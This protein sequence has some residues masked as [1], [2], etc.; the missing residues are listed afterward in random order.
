MAAQLARH[1]ISCRII[2]KNQRRTDLSRAL[3]LFARSLELLNSGIDAHALIE[4][5]I[6]VQRASFYADQKPIGSLELTGAH[7][8]FGTG[9][10]IPQSDTEQVL[11]ESLSP[12]GIRVERETELT[13]FEDLHD[14]VRCNLATSNGEQIIEPTWLI[15]CDGARSVIRHGL[16]MTFKGDSM[17]IRWVLADVRVEGV[18]DTSTL[19]ICPHA[20]GLLVGFRIRDDRLRIVATSPLA[21]LDQP[22]VDPDLADVQQLV[23][24]RGPGGWKV[25]D[26]VWLTEFRVN[27]RMVD[28]Y[29]AGHVFLAGD[30][31][32]IHSPAGG[33]GMNTG[34]QDACNLAW[35][36]ALVHRGTAN[37]NLLNS[38][39]T[40]RREVGR[41]VLAN[42]GRMTRV[43][44]MRWAVGR[45]IRNRV[46]RFILKRPAFQHRFTMF[47]S[48]LDIAYPKSPLTG[49]DHRG[50]SSPAGLK[51]GHRVPDLPLQTEHG[52]DSLHDVLTDP[53]LSL[54]LYTDTPNG[55]EHRAAL[56]Q[57]IP[58]AWRA[59]VQKICIMSDAPHPTGGVHHAPAEQVQSQLGLKAGN[60]ALIRP[61]GYV[62]LLADASNPACVTRWLE[63]MTHGDFEPD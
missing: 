2:D 5:G 29:Q 25:H 6:K 38:Y 62:A 16:N 41:R 55:L 27:E 10:L 12:L 37:A 17:M 56:E 39:T 42:S 47:L 22:R 54:L 45:A 59:S 9:L 3:G 44:T 7:S 60:C 50:H 19:F 52:T 61:D 26:P 18:D 40:E 23:D 13:G 58:E 33:Q 24:E 8:P 53:R 14:R 43:M 46:L 63:S 49:K 34:M 4:R 21:S 36:L 51:P 31:A 11:E 30:A 28:A 57:A 15:G 20:K 48:G 1:D 35:K 32:H